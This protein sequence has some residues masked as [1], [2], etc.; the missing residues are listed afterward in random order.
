[1]TAEATCKSSDLTPELSVCP[2]VK[3]ISAFS[4]GD[5]GGPGGPGGPETSL[6]FP[7]VPGGPDIPG[8][9]YDRGK[10]YMLLL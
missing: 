1:M 8:G 9:P 7:G 3:P 4:P 10:A 5:P 6:S 2:L